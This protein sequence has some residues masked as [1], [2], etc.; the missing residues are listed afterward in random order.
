MPLPDRPPRDPVG[1][2]LLYPDG[3]TIHMHAVN[4][5]HATTYR[6]LQLLCAHSSL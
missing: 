1:N 4:R 5:E 3:Y 6:L 2:G